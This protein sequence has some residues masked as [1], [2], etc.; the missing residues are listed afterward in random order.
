MTRS[1]GSVR[2]GQWLWH[3]MFEDVVLPPAWPVYVSQAEAGAFARWKGR[4][5]PTEAEYHRAAFGTPAASE[6]RLPV[7]NN[8]AGRDARQLRF[9]AARSR[10]RSDRFLRARA[11]G[12]FTI[13]SATAGNGR[14]DLRSVRRLRADGLV[15]GVLGGFF[16]RSALRHEGRVARDRERAGAP[17]LP[18]LVPAELSRT[19]TRR[20]GRS[21]R[22]TA[23]RRPPVAKNHI[24]RVTSLTSNSPPTC[25]AIWRSTRSSCNRSTSTTRWGQSLRCDLPVAVVSHH[26]SRTSIA[27]AHARR[28]RLGARRGAVDDRRA[29]VRQRREADVLAEALQAAAAPR[30]YTLLIFRRRRS[31]RP[32]SG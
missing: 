8:T 27:V 24:M 3:G 28:N 4:R 10:C 22:T 23:S 6:Q 15:S 16:R 31:S 21:D 2:D 30:A 20:S 26:A 17:Q 5:L 13:S 25:A 1:S 9:R 14:H 19:C 11:R 7:G 18:Q 12:A 29:R 32:S